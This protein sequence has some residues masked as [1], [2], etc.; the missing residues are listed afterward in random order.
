MYGEIGAFQ[1][2]SGQTAWMAAMDGGWG[3]SMVLRVA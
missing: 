3:Q 2:E 1:A